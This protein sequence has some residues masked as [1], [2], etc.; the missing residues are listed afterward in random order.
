MITVEKTS[1]TV[2]N[3]DSSIVIKEL[4]LKHWIEFI[5]LWNTLIKLTLIR[6]TNDTLTNV[7]VESKAV[8]NILNSMFEL[9]EINYLELTPT[10][11]NELLITHEGGEGALFK[12][13]NAFPKFLATQSQANPQELVS[14]LISLMRHYITL[15]KSLVLRHLAN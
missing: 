7:M 3:G 14:T 15:F 11:L 2:L 13:H 6:G 9:W 10:A 4:S 1:L 5:S 12:L 8:Q